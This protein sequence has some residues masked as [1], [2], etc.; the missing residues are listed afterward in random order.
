MEKLCK[1]AKEAA[2]TA[3]SLQLCL[4]LCNPIDGSPPGSSVPGILQ[5][6]IL[7]CHFPL[8]CMLSC[9]SHV[10]LWATL[11]TAAHQAPLSTGFSWQEY[12][13]G[14]P[15]PSQRKEERGLN[16]NNISCFDRYDSGK[17]FYSFY[18]AY[19]AQNY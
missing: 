1:T 4:A 7:E 13:S 6:R 18:F 5:A 10:Q 11:W 3:K 8:Q 17:I 2:A 12:W 9:F 19:V 14:L 15:F 16:R